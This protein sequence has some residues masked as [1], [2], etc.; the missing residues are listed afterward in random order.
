MAYED[1]S[2]R[3]QKQLGDNFSLRQRVYSKLVQ[4]YEYKKSKGRLTPEQDAAFR[5]EIAA[6]EERIGYD[7]ESV[8]GESNYRD[9]LNKAPRNYNEGRLQEYYGA[10]G[11]KSYYAT[12]TRTTSKGT[13]VYESKANPSRK[14]RGEFAGQRVTILKESGFQKRR[15]DYATMQEAQRRPGIYSLSDGSKIITQQ[16][17]GNTFVTE[18]GQVATVKKSR[19]PIGTDT[20]GARIYAVEEAPQPISRNYS[21]SPTDARGPD[22][23]YSSA[24][25][26]YVSTPGGPAIAENP[27]PQ[28]EKSL[29]VKTYEARKERGAAFYNVVK[30]Q[31]KLTFTDSLYKGAVETTS[32]AYS[33]PN[34]VVG[35]MY[36]KTFPEQEK[37]RSELEAAR[38]AYLVSNTKLGG[39]YIVQYGTNLERTGAIN[40]T[41]GK[42][43]V[44]YLQVATGAAKKETGFAI[45]SVGQLA[46]ENPTATTAA[47]VVVPTAAAIFGTAAGGA[48]T[49]AA[50]TRGVPYALATA[51]NFQFLGG[52]AGAIQLGGAYALGGRKAVYQEAP[53]FALAGGSFYAGYRGVGVGSPRFTE[54][55]STT[56]DAGFKT[57][58][59]IV[60]KGVSNL[61]FAGAT[62]KV[63]YTSTG[64]FSEATG[65]VTFSN[66]YYTN[67]GKSI[68]L[69]PKR[70]QFIGTQE[71]NVFT[72]TTN[73]GEPISTTFTSSREIAGKPGVFGTTDTTLTFETPRGGATQVKQ[74]LVSSGRSRN[75][76]IFEGVKTTGA[77]AGQKVTYPAEVPPGVD[78]PA[79]FT[80]AFKN[81]PATRYG[82]GPDVGTRGQLAI[83]RGGFQTDSIFRPGSVTDVGAIGTPK[84]GSA[85]R[86]ASGAFSGA[87][88]G[89]PIS[90]G[91]FVPLGVPFG[92]GG[93]GSAAGGQVRP[94]TLIGGKTGPISP[95]RTNALSFV[96]PDTTPQTTAIPDS[97]TITPFIPETSNPF[98]PR[99][100]TPP[101]SSPPGFGGFVPFPPLFGA[102]PP[103]GKGGLFAGKKRG[104]QYKSDVT[105]ILFNVRG[106]KP[107]GILS[108]L[109]T[110]PI[111]GKKR[112]KAK[113]KKRG[114][115]KK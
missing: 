29:G 63:S 113:A 41:E 24:R 57:N 65:K 73:K 26:G 86:I 4:K 99:P 33:I 68:F 11:A 58:Q 72:V 46:Y 85:P 34:F 67:T 39:A 30:A 10:G 75:L 38:G 53:F 110:R 43:N 62:E 44:N 32:L 82:F 22:F 96:T 2:R 97:G 61:E 79:L 47:L 94:L 21:Y 64:T 98:T 112:R 80:G 6:A 78:Q 84:A 109:E 27:I 89:V 3:E 93:A 36:G 77:T 60:I 14:T 59:K 106:K 31:R 88:L 70:G 101:P 25:F 45:K 12:T 81:A 92:L 19:Y 105:S 35:D 66:R 51:R 90:A 114:G 48:V 8:G 7:V 111:V 9:A 69:L 42:K 40:V 13:T 91:G 52:T 115:R 108:G 107:G 49:T 23:Q 103:G 74:T 17:V 56:R 20:S 102:I 55:F 18:K 50:A 37:K 87:A 100:S 83:G 76:P 16:G 71:G 95:T 104:F 5:R 15:A 28:P 54:V 1:L